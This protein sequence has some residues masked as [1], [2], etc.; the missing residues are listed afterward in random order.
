M[1]ELDQPGGTATASPPVETAPVPPESTPDSSGQHREGQAETQPKDGIAQP[2]ETQPTEIEKLIARMDEKEKASD[3][4]IATLEG[5]VKAT[6]RI[7]GH[8]A[9]MQISLDRV[10]ARLGVLNTHLT[11][12]EPNVDELR[13]KTGRYAQEDIQ[14]RAQHRTLELSTELSED[15][16]H[17]LTRFGADI[18]DAR[19]NEANAIWS[20][21]N[22]LFQ[23]NDLDGAE[24]L[25]RKADK[26]FRR[27]FD[28][29][30]D[31]QYAETNQENK[32]RTADAARKG[33]S[34]NVD[35]GG[36]SAG[37]PE[38]ATPENIDLLY[39]N[40]ER[41]HPTNRDNPYADQYR[42]LIKAQSR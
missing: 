23:Q 35:G 39:M 15:T 41:E 19:F 1:A 9:D 3:Q 13:Q 40:F 27:A 10:N 14:S 12:E 4:R 30:R 26:T 24:R 20:D 28:D 22:S 18:K 8:N 16:D 25:I 34:L 42:K 31:E 29:L 7:N 6:L 21:A 11:A 2:E 37:G 5:R 33:G 38:L 36:P 17:D 32:R